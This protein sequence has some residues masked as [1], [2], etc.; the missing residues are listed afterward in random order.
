V[1]LRVDAELF[2]KIASLSSPN[3]YSTDFAS[4]SREDGGFVDKAP[5][6]TK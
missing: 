2:K 1:K 4:E 5:F 3:L 6:P